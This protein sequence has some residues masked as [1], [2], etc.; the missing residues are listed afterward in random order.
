MQEM[1][2]LFRNFV[3]SPGSVGSVMPS[4]RYLVAAMISRVDWANTDSVVELGAGTGVITRAI[5]KSRSQGS[6]FSC[7]E[8]DDDMRSELQ[9]HYRGVDFYPDAFLLRESLGLNE[10]C[11]LDCVISGLPFANFH[12]HAREKLLRDIYASLN[13]GGVFLAFQYSRI[14]HPWLVSAY[15][16]L[17]SQRV[18]ANIPPAFVY[19]CRKE[20]GELKEAAL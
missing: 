3:S 1:W 16:E 7:F 20:I 12:R 6:R 4:S 8:R 18:W 5:E 13:P 17:E 11:G 19:F 10:T 9:K 15:G 2:T 14:L